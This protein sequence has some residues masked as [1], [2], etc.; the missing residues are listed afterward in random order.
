MNIDLQEVAAP[1]WWP[2]LFRPPSVTPVCDPVCEPVCRKGAF[3]VLPLTYFDLPKSAR[4]HLFP[5]SDRI[6][7]FCSDPM[8]VDPTD[9]YTDIDIDIDIY[10]YIYALLLW[11]ALVLVIFI[12][13]SPWRL[14][15]SSAP[16]SP[17]LSRRPE[18]GSW[19]RSTSSETRFA[20]QTCAGNIEC[21]YQ[22]S[23]INKLGAGEIELLPDV[24][25]QMSYLVIWV[26]YPEAHIRSRILCYH[27]PASSELHK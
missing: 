13:S 17:S 7:Y 15:A 14:W 21:L 6:H 19:P 16:W 1:P 4:A 5:Q 3:W 20:V 22:G 27:L 24:S 25:Y 12:M 23:F 18:D 11:L 26:V 10:I 9:I 2:R 8:S